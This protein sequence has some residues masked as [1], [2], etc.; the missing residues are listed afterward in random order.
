[1]V[2]FI[3]FWV[4]FEGRVD[5]LINVWVFVVFYGVWSRVVKL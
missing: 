4:N 3:G 2:V 5:N 1:M